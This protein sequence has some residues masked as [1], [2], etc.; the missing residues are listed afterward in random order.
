LEFPGANILAIHGLNVS[1][2]SSDFLISAE[3]VAGSRTYTGEVL[4][5]SAIEYTGPVT[6]DKS[7]HVK[8]RVLSSG[9]WSAAHEVTFG[10]GPVGDN[11]RITEIMYRPDAPNDPNDPN[12][13]YTELKNIGAEAINLNLVSF[14]NGINFTFPSLELAAG[15]YIVVVQDR[16]AFEARYGT[17]IDIAGEYTGRLNNGGERIRLQD[18]TGQTILDFSY[19]DG[20]RSITDGK[21]FSLTIIDPAN[22]NPASWDEKD[23]LSPTPAQ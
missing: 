12:E 11:L 9:Q 3:L 13:E 1:T 4:T 20:W 15:E 19:K 14:T 18:A 17:A 22:P 2:T 7:T 5:D 6:L 21:G 16:N 10:V 8:A 23:S